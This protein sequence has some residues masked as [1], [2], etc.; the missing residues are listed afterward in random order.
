MW[1]EAM[2]HAVIMGGDLDVIIDADATRSP[3]R[4]LV[5]LARQRLERRAI[6]L[7]EQLPAGHDESAD[8]PLF[9]EMLQQIG[10]RRVDLR[11]AVKDSM[12]QPPEKPSLDDEYRLL[13]FALSLGQ[14]GLPGKMA[15][16]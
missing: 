12:A 5:G 9:V 6:D 15:V 11:Q 7:F 3:F 13:D 14:L 1:G 4:E 16:S 10:D 8:R 2:G